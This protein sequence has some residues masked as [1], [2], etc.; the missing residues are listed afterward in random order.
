MLA[1]VMVVGQV[2]PPK[3]KGSDISAHPRL[4]SQKQD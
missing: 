2:L 3:L 4:G 1:V